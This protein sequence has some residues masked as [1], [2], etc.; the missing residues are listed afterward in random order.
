M[1][2][3]SYNNVQQIFRKKHSVKTN[4]KNISEENKGRKI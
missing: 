2:L 4:L 3:Q 1:N